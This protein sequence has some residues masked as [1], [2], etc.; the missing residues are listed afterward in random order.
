MPFRAPPPAQHPSVL[1]RPTS[2]TASSPALQQRS[3]TTPP[4]LGIGARHHATLR[5]PKPPPP[6][7]PL[8]LTARL[9][10][11]KIATNE[12]SVHEDEAQASLKRRKRGELPPS[13]GR[14]IVAE[15]AELD[16]VAEDEL[17]TDEAGPPAAGDANRLSVTLSAAIQDV[18]RVTPTGGFDSE[19]S[20]PQ[21]PYTVSL[22]TLQAAVA[23]P[24]EESGDL[25]TPTSHRNTAREP[26]IASS[27]GSTGL[28][29]TPV[30]TFRLER[31]SDLDDGRRYST[32]R[33]RDDAGQLNIFF[34]PRLHN[35]FAPD[36]HD[37]EP[38]SLLGRQ[39]MPT[40]TGV[41]LQDSPLVS[42]VT[43]TE[44]TV[45]TEE[46]S[47]LPTLGNGPPLASLSPINDSTLLPL[48]AQSLPALALHAFSGLTECGELSFEGGEEL[49]IEVE[50][51]GG[52]WSLGYVAREGEAGRGLIPRAWFA[53]SL[54]SLARPGPVLSLL[55]FLKIQYVEATTPSSQ[56]EFAGET[57]PSDESDYATRSI[58]RHVVVSGTEFEPTWFDSLPSPASPTLE[59]PS[60]STIP[61]PLVP[62]PADAPT[63]LQISNVP[64]ISDSFL[65]S[66]GL[67]SS[68]RFGSALLSVVGSA[69]SFSLPF[70]FGGIV[71]PGASILAAT[72][73]PTFKR[74]SVTRAPRLPR[75]ECD[76][77]VAKRQ[78]SKSLLLAWIE[79]GDEFDN[80]LTD[81][82]QTWEVAD[83]P[84]WQRA[85]G[86]VY[87]VS[88]HD[89]VVVNTASERLHVSYTVSTRF[90]EAVAESLEDDV[91]AVTRR[92][93]DFVAL[94]DLLRMR[95]FHP[96]V[97]FAPLPTK[98]EISF[99]SKRTDP[100]FLA[101]RARLL[102]EWMAD[103]CRHPVLG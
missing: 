24:S 59:A 81:V 87:R 66:L 41:A 45:A 14:S 37:S 40:E 74:D 4:P 5:L 25:E 29:R 50:D 102:T 70:S 31:M 69:F 71:V 55:T 95:F 27:T 20:P 60:T 92:F 68:A 85:R 23:P 58:G 3:P 51:V 48:P 46:V 53:V 56:P 77:R 1:V 22:D 36:R 10:H 82:T 83:G 6:P 42:K 30:G 84:A 16:D 72:S 28:F 47:E 7:K 101:R 34:D 91:Y 26:S 35:P 79:E 32:I 44:K 12:R 64:E 94:D 86:A 90:E 80:D 9:G 15:D 33:F 99:R 98:G 13:W 57:M 73:A 67:R 43:D 65:P 97:I 8:Y 96:L 89:P 49:R 76:W 88:I 38:L 19:D 21:S 54:K 75:P 17:Q 52:G 18:E 78:D 11:N 103:L 61:A 39:S 93:S 63:I 2:P 100:T 62:Q